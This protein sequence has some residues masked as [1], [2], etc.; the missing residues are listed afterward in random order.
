MLHFAGIDNPFGT[1]AFSPTTYDPIRNAPRVNRNRIA[2]SVR[3][4]VSN[5]TPPSTIVKRFLVS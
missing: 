5:P 4:F 3:K 2:G 1:D